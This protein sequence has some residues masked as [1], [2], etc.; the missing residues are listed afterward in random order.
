MSKWGHSSDYRSSRPPGVVFLKQVC[1]RGVTG[2]PTYPNIAGPVVCKLRPKDRNSWTK[3]CWAQHVVRVLSTCFDILVTENR[4]Y[5]HTQVQRRCT[6]LP[7]RLQHPQ[8]LHEKYDHFQI[9]ANN[10][11]HVATAWTTTRAKCCAQHVEICCVER[12]LSSGRGLKE[13]CLIFLSRLVTANISIDFFRY[14]FYAVFT[15]KSIA[16]KM[17]PLQ[18]IVKQTCCFSLLVNIVVPVCKGC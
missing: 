3:H 10:N 8:M 7:K 2:T 1:K 6:N 14:L 4:T 5:A 15:L 12:L 18:L 13:I 9:W 17:A 16:A 11:Q